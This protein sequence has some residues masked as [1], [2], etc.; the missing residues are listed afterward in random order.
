MKRDEQVYNGVRPGVSKNDS[1]E[2]KSPLNLALNEYSLL[3]DHGGAETTA[4]FINSQNS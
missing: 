3:Q 4:H 1:P 2:Y